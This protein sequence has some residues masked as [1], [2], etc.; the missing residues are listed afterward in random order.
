MIKKLPITM[1]MYTTYHYAASAGVVA[2]CNQTSDIWYFN[3]TVNWR[4]IRPTP[5][6]SRVDLCICNSSVWDIPFIKKTETSFRFIRGYVTEIIEEMLRQ[7]CYIIFGGV[8]DYFI[9][10][11]QHYMQ[12]H[13]GHDGLIVGFDSERKMLSMVAYDERRQ[14]CEFETPYEGFIQGV[15]HECELGEYGNL[16]SAEVDP[17]YVCTLDPAGIKTRLTEYMSGHTEEGYFPGIPIEVDYGIL[18]YGAVVEYVE[19]FLH[20]ELPPECLDQRIF[21]CI[22]EHKKCMSRRI[23]ALDAFLGT[24]TTLGEGYDE[25]ERLAGIVR[26]SALKAELSP[27]KR[28]FIGIAEKL[29]HLS[30]LENDNLSRVIRE[31]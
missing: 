25:V 14:Y 15:E 8:D 21:K 20:G 12:Q 13:F 28:V 16:T 22:Y 4:C 11:K 9:K 1:P 27:E 5:E 18:V 6:Y 24:G 2:A 23:A 31:L 26:M 10:G 17:D 7:N 3:N 19:M 30:E 29:R